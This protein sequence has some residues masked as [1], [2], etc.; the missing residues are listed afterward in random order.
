[1]INPPDNPARL[2]LPADWRVLL[3]GMGLTIAVTFLFGLAPALRASAVTP[4]LAL[5]GGEDPHARRRLMHGLVAAQAAFCFLVLFVA[6]LFTTTFERLSKL[7]MGFAEGVLLTLETVASTPQLPAYWEQVAEHLRSVPGV[8]AVGI[9]AW[10]LMS[11]EMRNNH[12]S[13][14]GEPQSDVLAFFL[15]V[16]PR[17]TDAMKIPLRNGRD[18]RANDGHPGVAIVNETFARTYFG[19]R[20]PVGQTFV[21]NEPRNAP[22]S[23]EIVGLVGDAVYR[24]AREPMLPVIY[25]PFASVDASGILQAKNRATFNV[26]ASGALTRALREEVSRA[27][28][29]VSNVRTQVEIDQS[30]TVRERLLAVLALFFGAVAVLLAGV[31]LYGVLNYSVLTRRR[32]I[33]IRRAIGAQAGDIA[34]SVTAGAFGMVLT[35]AT[36]GLAFGVVGARYVET[37]LYGVKASDPTM[38]AVPAMAIALAALL[39]AVPAVVHAV[40]I[41]PASMLRSE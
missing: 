33:G 38:L 11:G 31:G 16:S 6:G 1:M 21:S 34:R 30:H 4:A 17:W 27:G 39:A 40:R 13:V 20:N 19:G 26:R 29:R 22:V 18:F 9:S 35:G 36:A 2:V 15:A 12:V 14:N 3:F 8:S 37:L 23:Y 41:D 28:F 10:P 5:K 24:D 32:E 7:P 25:V